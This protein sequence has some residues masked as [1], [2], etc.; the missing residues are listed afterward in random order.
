MMYGWNGGWGVWGW[1]LMALMML[2]FWGG[3]ASLAAVAVLAVPRTGGGFAR[4]AAR[5]PAW[6][7]PSS[8]SPRPTWAVP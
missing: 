1:V 8:T 6:P 4:A 2:I 5:F 3:V 7:E